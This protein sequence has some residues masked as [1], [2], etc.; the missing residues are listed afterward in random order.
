MTSTVRMRC[1]T[2]PRL[3]RCDTASLGFWF[4][5]RPLL[6]SPQALEL[7]RAQTAA[8]IVAKK[9]YFASLDDHNLCEESP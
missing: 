7:Q 9:K 5:F 4:A 6:W 8:F 3:A 2:H 1:R